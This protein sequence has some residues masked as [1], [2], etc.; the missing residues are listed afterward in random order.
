MKDRVSLDDPNFT[1]GV[2]PNNKPKVLCIV[3]FVIAAIVI[4]VANV[5]QGGNG[6]GNYGNGNNVDNSSS[7]SNCMFIG[8][9]DPNRPLTGKTIIS[10]EPK[11]GYQAVYVDRDDIYNTYHFH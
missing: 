11:Y 9:S 8:Y 6:G 10:H 7:H 5:L 4:I 3:L 2:V 1:E